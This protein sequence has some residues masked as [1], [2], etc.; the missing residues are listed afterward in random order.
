MT[1]KTP[2]PVEQRPLAIRLLTA[3]DIDG[4]MYLKNVSG[5][6]QMP[7]DW[8]LVL[9][10][11]PEGCFG[12][13]C[14]G[15]LVASS[16]VVEYGTAL[17]W[18]GMV[19]VDPDYRRHGFGRRLT[20]A[21]VIRARSRTQVVMLDASVFGQPLYQKLGFREVSRVARWTGAAPVMGSGE[22]VGPLTPADWAEVAATDRVVFGADRQT[23]LEALHRRR[24]D[25]AFVRRRQGRVVAYGLG[26]DGSLCQQIGPVVAETPDDARAVAGAALRALPGV[27]VQF[28]VPESQPGM[29][30]W[31]T[32]AGFTVQRTFSRMVLGDATVPGDTA[33]A[34]AAAGPEFG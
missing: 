16:V 10:L 9:R 7:D 28:D 23:L 13:F 33:R 5:W 18:I 24:P 3:A 4:C 34:F 21:A 1:H 15:R 29:T 25:L 11:N 22:G 8:R 26:R 2:A 12:G 32:D 19:L 17:S 30:R 31:L 27:K 6:N 20:E 14:D